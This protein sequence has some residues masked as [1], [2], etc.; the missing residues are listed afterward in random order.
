[1]TGQQERVLDPRRRVGA[2]A[3]LNNDRKPMSHL[4]PL[5]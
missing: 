1:M 5:T 4:L 2:P 3:M